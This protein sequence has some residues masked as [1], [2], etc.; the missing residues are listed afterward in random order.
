MAC[1][2]IF[3]EKS[4]SYDGMYL[5]EKQINAKKQEVAKI[6]IFAST[7]Y[8]LYING[9]YICEG[10]CRGHEKTRYYDSV[11][12]ELKE[13]IN[14]IC[15]KVMHLGIAFTTVFKTPMPMVAFEAVTE[16]EVFISD[17]TWKCK[18]LSGYKF[19][20]PAFYTICPYEKVDAGGEAVELPVVIE[21]AFESCTF[22]SDGY[23]NVCGCV[24]PFVLE[25]RPIP[26]IYPGAENVLK[27]IKS[28]D[29][30]VE[31]DAG[32]YMTAKM[33]FD[34]ASNSNVTITYSECYEFEDGKKK[35]DDSN[36]FLNGYSDYVKTADEDI[37]YEPFWF[38]AFR[39]IRV[40]GDCE[41]V[42][43]IKAY[44]CNYPIDFKGSFECSD[45]NYNKMFDV[46]INTMLCCA[47]EIVVDCP[48]YEQQQYVMDSAI[49]HAVMMRMTDD[50]RLVKKCIRDFA[51]SQKPSGLLCAQ[52]PSTYTQIIP[53][54]SFFWIFLLRSYLED[55]KDTSYVS[56]FVGKADAVLG[57]FDRLC[58]DRGYITPS[59]M[60]DYVDWVPEWE[61]G[62]VPV[63][64]NEALTIYNL[65]YACALKDAAFI[66]RKIGRNGLASDYE[67]RYEIVKNNINN[68][69]YNEEKGM[70][71]DGSET[72]TYS[73]HTIIWAILS[74]VVPEDKKDKLISHI[75]DEGLSKSS[76]SFIFYL[77]RAFEKCGRYDMAFELFK[78][79]QIMLDNH[80]TTWCE[81]PDNPRSECHAWSCAPYYEFSA[82]ILGVKVGYD[83]EIIIAPNTGS[84]SYAKGTVPTRFGTVSVDWTNKNGKFIIKVSG[85]DGV[86]KKV[87]M[88]NGEEYIFDKGEF[89]Y[90]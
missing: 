64:D 14:D 85:A 29:G 4:P 74:E 58:A 39:F 42:G 50:R 61:G 76:F 48:F 88:M 71:Q 25:K 69:C 26:M 84:L 28:G 2:Y 57:Y 62:I 23:Y 3:P 72:E 67:E 13:G 12:V 24:H 7:R 45:E 83:D 78:N 49:E 82:N 32:E 80:C 8:I 1:Y 55:S 46:S 59:N 56:E 36:G 17:E 19:Y 43:S 37:V 18:Y 79:W 65:Y 21:K 11:E 22:K 16:D 20:N 70:Y 60:W 81:N 87:I 44:R 40:E 77:F 38:R 31:Y 89:E 73:M 53:G 34:I 51:E 5:F 63:K 47:H 86:T 33:K 41:A 35:R 10:P 75:F 9:E 90:V 66:C 52:Y 54:F 15:V 6:N 30:F 68:L 27:P